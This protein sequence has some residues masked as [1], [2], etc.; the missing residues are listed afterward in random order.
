[1]W[2]GAGSRDETFKR[3]GQSGGGV[4]DG[5]CEGAGPVRG[6]VSTWGRAVLGNHWA[7]AKKDSRVRV[8]GPVP[9]THHHPQDA[10]SAEWSAGKHLSLRPTTRLELERSD[11]HQVL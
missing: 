2:E 6:V 3:T 7:D 9:G 11:C 4:R 1:M 10:G 8:H 5:K